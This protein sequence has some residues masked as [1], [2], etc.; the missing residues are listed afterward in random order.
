MK[1]IERREN[2]SLEQR[3]DFLGLILEPTR[4]QGLDE[5]LWR[6]VVFIIETHGFEL[7][8]GKNWFKFEDPTELRQFMVRKDVLE[9]FAHLRKLEQELDEIEKQMQKDP[10]YSK[11]QKMIQ[12]FDDKE[13][14][15]AKLKKEMP[16]IHGKIT[17]LSQEI[18]V[19]KE[20]VLAFLH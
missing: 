2:R 17:S 14:I 13:G 9:K 4:F 11:T 10:Q 3:E 12:D 7:V 16:E 5:E 15:I 18:E 1:M 20:K 6:Q 8:S 19:D